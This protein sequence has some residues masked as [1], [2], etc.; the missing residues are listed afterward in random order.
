VG[1]TALL[2]RRSERPPGA[3]EVLRR[4]RRGGAPGDPSSSV[5]REVAPAAVAR[6][7]R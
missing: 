1:V 5:R 6:R 3:P 2:V 4:A 7:S